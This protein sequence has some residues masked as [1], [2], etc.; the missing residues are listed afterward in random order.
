MNSLD[1]IG[2][3]EIKVKYKGPRECALGASLASIL[4]FWDAGR[5][6]FLET[7]S[8]VVEPIWQE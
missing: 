6:L 3:K 7:A 4:N 1:A 2:L 5:N 8:R